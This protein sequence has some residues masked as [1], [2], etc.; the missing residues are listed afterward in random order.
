MKRIIRRSLGSLAPGLL[1]APIF[2]QENYPQ[3]NITDVSDNRLQKLVEVDAPVSI[4]IADPKEG[5]HH[6]S[7]AHFF[8]S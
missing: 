5:Q 6:V 4:L 1:L 2:R 3:L 8:R 7:S